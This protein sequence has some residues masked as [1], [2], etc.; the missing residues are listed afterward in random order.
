MDIKVNF[1]RRLNEV[2]DI[3]G[4][5]SKGQGRQVELARVMKV[6]QKGARKWL[7]GVGLPA[8]ETLFNLAERFGVTVGWL[9]AGDEMSPTGISG[10]GYYSR[11]MVQMAVSVVQEVVI[12]KGKT[13]TREEMVI[14]VDQALS[15]MAIGVEEEG[16]RMQDIEPSLRL[17]MRFTLS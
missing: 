5:P 15:F 6:S 17:H 9:L 16:L 14:W 2:L 10:P 1:A 4:F 7:E 3:N 13:P 12:A 8:A 11:E